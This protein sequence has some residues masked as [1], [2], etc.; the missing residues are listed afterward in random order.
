MSKVI[1]G[2][3]LIFATMAIVKVNASYCTNY[4]EELKQI[5]SMREAVEAIQNLPAAQK[6]E[7]NKQLEQECDK[8]QA[9]INA[10]SESELR[11]YERNK[12]KAFDL[13]RDL[14]VSSGLDYQ[15]ANG[16]AQ[17]SKRMADDAIRRRN[18]HNSSVPIKFS[19]VTFILT[20]F[21]AYIV[22]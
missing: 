20:L 14:L 13:V 22:G 8:L 1:F 11:Q 10:M 2:I 12:D 9:Q 17:I 16:F 5:D 21:L 15:T 4:L 7:M 18:A 6:R 3:G 19:F